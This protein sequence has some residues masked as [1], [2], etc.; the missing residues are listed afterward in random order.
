[1]DK[2]YFAAPALASRPQFD[3]IRERADF[4][5]ILADAEAGR[6]R[7]LQTFRDGGG[8]RLLGL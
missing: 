6:R 7:A 5:A 2:G 8:E 3:A 1:V 4:T